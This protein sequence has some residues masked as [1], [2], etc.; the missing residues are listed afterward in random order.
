MTEAASARPSATQIPSI[1]LVAAGGWVGRGVQVVAQLVAV[2]ILTDNL[3]TQG[4][5]AFAVLASLTGW[6]LLADLSLGTSLQNHI[7]ERRAAGQASGDVIVSAALLALGST[8]VFAAL[9]VL[10]APWLAAQ[11]LGGFSLSPQTRTLAF[12]AVALPGVG[13][14]LGGVAYRIW[15]ARHRGYL[16]NLLPALGAVLGTL[17]VWALARGGGAALLP[18]SVALYYAPVALLPIAALAMLAGGAGGG[19]RRALVAPL[20]HRALR[21][22]AFGLLAAGV[23]Q[24]DFI[25]MARLL[26]A[27]D[28]V[29]Y[30]LASK[31]FLLVFFVYNALL[32][33]LWPVCSEAI[34][35]GEWDRVVAA[36]RR[37]M[38]LGALF[39]LAGG[40]AFALLNH[41]VV[42]V[43]APAT[44]VTVPLLVI[45]L[46]TVYILVRV[47]AD[48]FAMVLQS[49]ND[50]TV[51]WIV[52]PAQSLLS[53]GLQTLGARWFGLPGM[54]VGLTACFVLT[55][56]WALPLRCRVQARRARG[57]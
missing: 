30:S 53:I 54:I 27:A 28:I 26:G 17:G 31:V 52:V 41:Q 19:F 55:V 11:L 25:I 38:I 39:T 40:A 24:V 1:W 12:L 42:A 51:L 48:T 5:G 8:L 29:V 37:Y 6:F 43:L 57:I 46:L 14:A 35:R 3:G 21:F 44:Q 34:A 18:E 13:T 20:L 2:R 4:Y 9:A 16:A 15:F 23:L 47:W 7:S 36:V 49:M 33:A 32:Q 45:A 50:L 56:A 10:A 22:W